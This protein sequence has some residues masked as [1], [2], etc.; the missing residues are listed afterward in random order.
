M[1]NRLTAVPSLPPPPL[2]GTALRVVRLADAFMVAMI[3]RPAS[4]SLRW[5]W[6]TPATLL[7]AAASVV[8]ALIVLAALLAGIGQWPGA[9]VFI[10]TI[11]CV[12]FGTGAA[13][14]VAVGIEQ[15]RHHH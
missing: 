1:S 10:G 9:L 11:V 5:T 8:A 4:G 14:V 15:R 7:L 13:S 12:A 3:S 6:V 2:A